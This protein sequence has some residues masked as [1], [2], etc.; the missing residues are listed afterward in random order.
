MLLFPSL[1]PATLEHQTQWMPSQCEE[2]L[3]AHEEAELEDKY[4][5]IR[6]ANATLMPIGKINADNDQEEYEADA[7]EDD[8]DNVEEE[9]EGE[10]FDQET[11]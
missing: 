6:M 1:K 4:N 5:E 3:L 7:E 9:S 8:A 2:A 10:D 11:G